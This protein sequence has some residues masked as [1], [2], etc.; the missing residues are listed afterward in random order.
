MQSLLFFGGVN[1][2]FIAFISMFSRHFWFFH[3]V[4]GFAILAFV[5]VTI[6]ASVGWFVGL[7]GALSGKQ[8]KLPFVSG[9][10]ERFANKNSV[11]K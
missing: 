6:I 9:Y 7:F 10:A 8:V 2:L 4:N 5:L 11:V 3:F 1:V